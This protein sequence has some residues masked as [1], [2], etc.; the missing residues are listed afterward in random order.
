M[1]KTES[2][3]FGGVCQSGARARVGRV[4]GWAAIVLVA[5]FFLSGCSSQVAVDEAPTVTVQI[6]A[7]E[8]ETIQRK[9]IADASLYPL[10]QAAIVAKVNAPVSKFYVDRGSKVRAGQLLAEL[11][12]KDLAATVIENQGGYDQAQA[13]YQVA[14]QKA[15][16]DLKLAKDV[17]DG[18]QKVYE[19]R[20]NL[21]K[22][23]AVSAKDVDD[24]RVSL[25]QAQNQ[26]E[27]AQKQ[28]DLKA[29][30]GNVTAAKGRTESATAQPDYTKIV[31]PIDG[32]VTD[33]PIY[34]GETAA[35]GTPI[36]TVMDLSAIV[37]R[38]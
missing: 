14:V 20:Q 36:L 18:A 12:N 19:S 15:E 24:A 31:S 33:R 27:A 35:S 10:N 3:M 11:E 25:T 9:V 34:P 16:Q 1:D 8:K 21:Y 26:S 4:G 30:A 29:A 7:A 38:A 5:G 2:T 22:Q 23:G 37:A 32:M 13:A 17:L 6:D 28:L